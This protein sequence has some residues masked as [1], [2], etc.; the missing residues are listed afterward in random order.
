MATLGTNKDIVNKL[1][2][3]FSKY[4][5]KFRVGKH[6]KSI[7]L[8]STMLGI[9]GIGSVYYATENKNSAL[10]TMGSDT[11]TE[12][13]NDTNDTAQRNGVCIATITTCTVLLALCAIV[14]YFITKKKKQP[15]I[16]CSAM[17]LIQPINI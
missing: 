17:G 1:E 11:D 5:S 9:M 14:T 2:T 15:D 10:D 16:I 12:V 3:K 6:K 8:L 7:A 13:L 4:I